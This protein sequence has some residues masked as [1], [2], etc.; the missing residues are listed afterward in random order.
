MAVGADRP[1][2]PAGV[3]R[4]HPPPTHHIRR[5]GPPGGIVELH[6]PLTLLTD[7]QPGGPL[8]SGHWA[9]LIADITTQYALADDQRLDLDTHPDARHP[10]AALRRHTEIRDRTCTF[11]ACRRRAHTAEHDHTRDY[12][13]GGTTTQ[14]NIGP[15]CPH[16]HQVKHLGGWQVTQPEP[17]VFVWRS[18]LGG[19]YPHHRRTVPATHARPHTHHTGVRP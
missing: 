7:L 14:I 1:R 5:D 13:H 15:L 3:R 10:S 8:A 16:D 6:I 17:G 18:P 4:H 12:H 9:D 2:R 11:T 19:E